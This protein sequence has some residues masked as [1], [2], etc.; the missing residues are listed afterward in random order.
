MKKALAGC[1]TAWCLVAALPHASAQSQPV[2]LT[3]L[4]KTA[5]SNNH[6]VKV[7]ELDEQNVDR[8]IAETRARSLPQVNGTGNVTDNYKRQVLVLPAGLMPGTE[9]GSGPTKIVAGTKYSAAVGVEATQPLLDMAAFSGLKAAKAGREYYAINT[10]KTREEIIH[11]VAQTYYQIRA[12]QEDARLQQRTIEILR[13]L[14][15]ASEGQYKNGLARKVDLDRIR[16]NLINAQ[17]KH[18]QAQQDVTS[19]TNSLKVI[20]GLPLTA[21]IVLDTLAMDMDTI[22]GAT[23]QAEPE[24]LPGKQT[25]ILLL[26]SQIRLSTLERNSIRAENYPKL[27]AFFNYS[28]NISSNDLGAV[29]TGQDPAIKYGMGSWGIRL[30]VPIFDGLARHSRAAQSNIKIRKYQQQRDAAVL[31]M[32]ANYENARL[33]M[34]STLTTIK[35]QKQNVQLSQ[36]VYQ[37]T[38]A[39][40]NLGLSPLTDLLDAQTSFLEAQNIYTQSLLDYKLAELEIM[41]ASG[42]LQKLAE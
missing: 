13:Q 33:Q 24:Y 21:P 26:E 28:H 38:R 2:S 15:Q 31:Q 41:R 1:L 11:N 7:S 5:L 17:S 16:V 42:T 35:A 3:E 34:I 30:Q 40:Y 4:L 22:P 9:G 27:T 39:N 20:L 23:N 14:V 25:D 18:T 36:E 12:S 32:D 6:D 37:S 10:R 19:K 29:F 8:Q